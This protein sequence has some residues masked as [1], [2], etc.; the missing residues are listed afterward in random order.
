MMW[1]ELGRQQPLFA[2]ALGEMGPAIST[3]RYE[4]ALAQAWAAAPR[5]SIDFAVM[6]GAERMAVIPVDIDWSDIGT[7]ASLLDVMSGDE[8]G[9][10]VIGDFMGVDTEHTLVRGGSRLIAT[11]GLKN[12]VIIDT[13]DVL[14]I[15]P[16][17]RVQEVKTMV[18]QL[19][20]KRRDDVL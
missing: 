18:E 14:L 20:A 11:I 3:S 4:A 5:K 15:C 6:E 13:P 16:M 1:H 19:R 7:W 17:E 2:A 10:V 9:N 8:N 12:L